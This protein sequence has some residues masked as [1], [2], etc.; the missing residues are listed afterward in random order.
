M[1]LRSEAKEAMKVLDEKKDTCNS[2]I[3]NNCKNYEDNDDYMQSLDDYD[4]AVCTWLELIGKEFDRVH[5]TTTPVK[6]EQ[7]SDNVVQAMLT[8]IQKQMM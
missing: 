1:D 4:T 5:G 6:A 2:L 3:A 8:Q 7:G